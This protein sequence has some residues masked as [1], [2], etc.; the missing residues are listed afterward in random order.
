MPK[1]LFRGA[2]VRFVD[3]RFDD[4]SK[5]TY[6]K[7]N[8]TASF[9]EPIR[10][11]MEWGAPPPGFSSAKLDGS[12][13]AT[14]LVLTP[15]GRE[16]KTHELQL[17]AREIS[18]FEFHRVKDGESTAEEL[19]FQIVTSVDG[20]AAQ[21]EQYIRAIGKGEG[22]LRVNYEQQSELPLAEDAQEPLI[23]EEQAADTADDGPTLAT[24]ATMRDAHQRGKKREPIQ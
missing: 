14:H 19:R 9:S 10:E 7:L 11:A 20:A 12:M 24:A 23:S 8:F 15:N 13:T 2:Y 17:D 1:L 21:I 4:K 18:G 16:L 22:Q 3:L 6:T 5:T